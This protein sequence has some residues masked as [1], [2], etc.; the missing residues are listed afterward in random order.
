MFSNPEDK[1]LLAQYRSSYLSAYL[2]MLAYIK[3]IEQQHNLNKFQATNFM[4]E[5]FA[6]L[7]QLPW[8]ERMTGAAELVALSAT[9]CFAELT[10]QHHALQYYN[11]AS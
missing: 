1:K 4:L 2:W 11:F 5:H 8:T 10:L 7:E 6:A 9:D 3:R